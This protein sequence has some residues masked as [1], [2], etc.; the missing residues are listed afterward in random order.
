MSDLPLIAGLGHYLVMTPSGRTL[1]TSEPAEELLLRLAALE[2][3]GRF[4]PTVSWSTLTEADPVARACLTR[5]FWQA[6]AGP[7]WTRITNRSN[8]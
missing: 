5:L 2:A 3:S 1:A 7:E 8:P 6:I 4:P